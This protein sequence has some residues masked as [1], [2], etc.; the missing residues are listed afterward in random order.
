M[1]LFVVTTT[2]KVLRVPEV[3]E[4]PSRIAPNL[5]IFDDPPGLAVVHG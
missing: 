1:Q 2:G 3:A 5:P 4:R